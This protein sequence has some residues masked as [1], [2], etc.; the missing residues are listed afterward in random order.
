MLNSLA[1]TYPF[2]H[3]PPNKIIMVSTNSTLMSWKTRS[4]W[5]S[6]MYDFCT[7]Q[8]EDG[9][10]ADQTDQVVDP[11]GLVADQTDPTDPVVVTGQGRA[12]EVSTREEAELIKEVV[13]VSIQAQVE[14]ILEA[15]DP[16]LEAVDQILEAEAPTKAVEDRIQAAEVVIRQVNYSYVW[17]MSKGRYMVKGFD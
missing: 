14:T 13:V 11:A 16:I 17:R 4:A 12:A 15:V 3:F 10:G 8:G 6:S 7:F 5:H 1:I 9:Q 2:S